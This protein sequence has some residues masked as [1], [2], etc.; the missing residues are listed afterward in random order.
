MYGLAG[1]V[2]EVM[3]GASWVELL[4]TRLFQPLGMS[5]SRVLGRT[6]TVDANNFAAPYIQ[7][8]ND[9]VPSDPAIY[10]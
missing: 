5:D 4:Q 1:R 10:R 6:V 2:A 3:G 7:T 8:G 9:V